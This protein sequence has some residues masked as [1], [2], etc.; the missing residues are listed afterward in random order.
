MQ[1]LFVSLLVALAPEVVHASA[2]SLHY[3]ATPAPT[4]SGAAFPL[5]LGN[6][7]QPPIQEDAQDAPMFIRRLKFAGGT[8]EKSGDPH[9]C[10]MGDQADHDKCLH[11]ED[12][13]CMWTRVETRDPLKRVQASNSYCLPCRL[14]GQAIPCWNVGAWVDGKQVT[15]CEMS[16][17]HQ[18]IIMQPEYV[19]TDETGAIGQS[20][21]FGKGAKT[22]SKCMFIAFEDSAGKQKGFCG[23]CAVTG[24]GGWGCP[25]VGGEGPEA[26]SKVKSCLSQCDVL[27]TGPPACPP[28][29]APPPPPPPPAPGIAMVAS[30]ED[31]ML[32][33][34]GPFAAPTVNP[35]GVMIAAAEA[36]KKAG[37]YPPTTPAPKT[38]WPVI[39]YRAPGDYLYTTGPPLQAGP[40]PPLDMS[41]LQTKEES[42]KQVVTP[43][44]R[45]RH[46]VI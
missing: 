39:Y 7:V 44:R 31:T 6:Q 28:T 36:A 17:V 8:E 40:E 29:V 46:R 41:L 12:R 3:S 34:P 38:Y 21:C 15:N 42:S 14:D 27:C 16:C 2:L 43:L 25:P 22:G 37:F 20:E 33:A 19:C 32:N 26:G 13:S 30:P 45:L 9:A 4:I 35:Y 5:Y 11:V 10:D 1:C 23:P 18:D 24:T